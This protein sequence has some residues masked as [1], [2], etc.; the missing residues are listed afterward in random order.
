[1][2]FK[3]GYF[4]CIGFLFLFSWVNQSNAYTAQEIVNSVID[5][6]DNV[7]DYQATV[8]ADFSPAVIDDMTGGTIKWKRNSGTWKTKILGGSPYTYNKSICNGTGYNIYDNASDPNAFYYITVSA[9][10]PIIRGQTAA[11]M[12]NMEQILA[13]ETW[14]KDN[15]T[16]TVNNVS[17]YRV[18]TSKES[19]N[20]EVWID[21]AT[22]TKVIRSK[23]IDGGDGPVTW[24]LDYSDYTNVEN[25]AQ[26]PGTI[27]AT[28]YVGATE[29][30]SITWTISDIDI[31]E[32]LSDSIFVI[33]EPQQ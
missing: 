7:A 14:S 26:L 15:D 2:K 8:D 29:Q 18:Y 33:D 9:Y 11:D 13:A 17:C 10:A 32:S 30:Y 1:M 19:D 16:V 31:N 21:E 28:L 5:E 4:A 24:I 3:K 6:L 23:W 20:Y 27:F 22:R 12:F 25:T